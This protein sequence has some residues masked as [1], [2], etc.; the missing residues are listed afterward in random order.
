MPRLR[1]RLPFRTKTTEPERGNAVAAV[2]ATLEANADEGAGLSRRE[3]RELV[4]D[5]ADSA[6][7]DVWT[8]VRGAARGRGGR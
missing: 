7:R 8:P 5:Q 1:F 6:E 3:F 4:H 2:V